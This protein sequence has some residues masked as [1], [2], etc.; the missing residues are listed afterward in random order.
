[1]TDRKMVATV[2]LSIPATM[3]MVMSADTSFR[4]LGTVLGIVDPAE[5]GT[6]TGTAEVA[7]IALTLYAWATRA[8]S[9]AWIAYA[10]VL[11]QALPAFDVSGGYGGLVR[12]ALGPVLLVV[13]LHLLLGLELRMSRV[14]PSG[15]LADALREVRERLVAYL[16]IGRRGSDSASIARS[17]AADRAVAL[18]DRVAATTPGSRRHRRYTA[19]LARALDGARH[20][21]GAFEA[22]A[23]EEG[24]VARVVRRKSVAGL[25]GIQVQYDWTGAPR[26]ET[27]ALE[28]PVPVARPVSVQR[29]VPA[30][31]PAAELFAPG[32]V[33]ETK[34][35]LTA[36]EAA[37]VASQARGGTVAPSTIRTWKHR[38]RL[39]PVIED[40]MTLYRRD[41]VLAAATRSTTIETPT[42]P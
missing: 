9:A 24:I 42:E 39:T 4:F 40:E 31:R 35:L 11:V 26:N 2:G 16:G 18:V 20:G 21:L 32:T 27:P 7:V 12:M 13:L 1:M 14:R 15:I 8:R 37:S 29:P 38:G 10:V 5:R 17:R 19:E 3:A 22:Q 30:K 28:T 34:E 23:V 6:L 25:A 41:D 36:T 33:D